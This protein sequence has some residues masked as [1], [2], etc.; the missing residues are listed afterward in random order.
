MSNQIKSNQIKSNQIK[1]NQIKSR[2]TGCFKI[3][4]S[5][6]CYLL[7]S[8]LPLPPPE[9]EKNKKKRH[10]KYNRIEKNRIE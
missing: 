5:T 8:P 3:S 9:D 7:L 1:S 4:Y 6:V 2:Y 10:T